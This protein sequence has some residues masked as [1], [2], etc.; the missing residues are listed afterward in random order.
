MQVAGRF[1]D[2]SDFGSTLNGKLASRLELVDGL[3]LRGA[4]STGFRAPSLQQQFF[5]AAATN[6]I[7]GVLVD[8]VTLPVNNPVAIA[9][10]ATPL[11]AEKSFSWSAG[12]QD[13]MARMAGW[14]LARRSRSG[15]GRVR[16]P[17]SPS[18]DGDGRGDA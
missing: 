16:A 15:A 17:P 6:N 2:Y 7:G 11:K 12:A 4:V 5:A 8:A 1:E 9:L 10:G 13:Q 14:R 3:A 18:R